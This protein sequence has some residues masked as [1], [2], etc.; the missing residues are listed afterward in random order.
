M[1]NKRAFTLAEVIIVVGILGLVAEMTIP[2]LMQNIRE[3]TTVVALK[4]AYS[5]LSQAYTLAVQENGTPDNWGLTNGDMAGVGAVN[6]LNNLKPYLRITKDCGAGSGCYPTAMETLNKTIYLDYNTLQNH[7]KIQLTD[8]S[9][10]AFW[11]GSSNCSLNLGST[12]SLSNICGAIHVDI[13]GFKK[14]NQWGVDYF[15]FFVTKFGIIPVGSALEINRFVNDCRD[16]T[17]AD[18]LGCTAWVIYNENLD[19]LHCSDLAWGG[20]TKC[21]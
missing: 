11:S 8:G 1:N 18:G 20:K 7:A 16:K 5:T 21:D 15:Q 9:I 14:P 10:M 19:Y 12:Q 17:T 2:T 3:Q 4:K 13:N 6:L